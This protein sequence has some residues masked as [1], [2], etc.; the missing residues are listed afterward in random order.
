MKAHLFKAAAFL[1]PMPEW[2]RTL[3]VPKV[4]TV[5]F[6]VFGPPAGPRSQNEPHGAFTERVLDQRIIVNTANK[7]CFAAQ[8]TT[9]FL[10]FI[11]LVMKKAI[12]LV[13][14]YIENK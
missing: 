12:A 11:F 2:Q 3:K 10:N 4:K 8:T 5:P 13:S 14:E 6:P 7:E 1:L 9:G